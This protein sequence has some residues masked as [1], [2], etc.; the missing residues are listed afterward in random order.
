[1]VTSANPPGGSDGGWT[2]HQTGSP[3]AISRSRSAF[4]SFEKWILAGENSALFWLLKAIAAVRLTPSNFTS[5]TGMVS[6]EAL[7]I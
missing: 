4:G 2:F 5:V 7:R 3:A 6:A 1:M